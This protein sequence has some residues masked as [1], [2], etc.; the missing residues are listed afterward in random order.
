MK[1]PKSQPYP[2]TKVFVGAVLYSAFAEEDGKS[3]KTG[4]REW[5]V[6]SIRAERRPRHRPLPPG[7]EPTKYVELVLKNC[8]TWGKLS[9]K[10]GDAG[11]KTSISADFRETFRVGRPLPL[12]IYTTQR[13]ALAWELANWRDMVEHYEA[14]IAH[15]ESEES[16]AEFV[17]ELALTHRLIEALQ[18][19]FGRM[20]KLSLRTRQEN[21]Q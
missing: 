14:D 3:I 20:K 7:V 16:K 1:T 11:W 15:A 8:V 10:K 17:A 19:R 12:G 13:A 4:F 18:R 6:R 21:T 5:V 9:P 2:A